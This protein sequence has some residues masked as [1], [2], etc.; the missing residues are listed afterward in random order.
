MTEVSLLGFLID[1]SDLKTNCEYIVYQP[2]EDLKWSKVKING[3][4][5]FCNKK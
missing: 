4:E 1:F 5:S 3:K 2:Q